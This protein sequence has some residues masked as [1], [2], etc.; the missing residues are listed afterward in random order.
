MDIDVKLRKHL[1]TLKIIHE[2]VSGNRA[3]FSGLVIS[4]TNEK[5]RRG[6][7]YH[8]ILKIAEPY[9]TADKLFIEQFGSH[10]ISF[11]Q[12]RKDTNNNNFI[13]K[14]GF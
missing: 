11:D 9:N 12:L 13:M 3:Q 2:T 10:P 5:T 8:W 7:S 1:R 14:I 4:L 6:Q